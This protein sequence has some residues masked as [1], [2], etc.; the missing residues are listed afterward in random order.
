MPYIDIHN[1]RVWI[2]ER[3][4][5][6][7]DEAR[8]MRDGDLWRCPACGR[9]L[10]EEENDDGTITLVCPAHQVGWGAGHEDEPYPMGGLVFRP[11][12]GGGVF[13]A[14]PCMAVCLDRTSAVNAFF[15]LGETYGLTRIE[16]V[17]PRTHSRAGAATR[18]APPAGRGCSGRPRWTAARPR[19]SACAAGSNARWSRWPARPNR[20]RGPC[21]RSTCWPT[22]WTRMSCPRAHGTGDGLLPLVH[23]ARQI[24]LRFDEQIERGS[25]APTPKPA[26]QA[27][28]PVLGR[29][30]GVRIDA[31]QVGVEQQRVG[32]IQHGLQPHELPGGHGLDPARPALVLADMA[33]RGADGA[34][35]LGLRHARPE[36]V[37]GIHPT[38]RIHAHSNAHTCERMR[39]MDTDGL[40][41]EQLLVDR[42]T[43]MRMLGVRDPRTVNKL[44]RNGRITGFTACGRWYF[45][46]A[47][48]E[49]FARGE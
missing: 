24:E 5:R 39:D 6:S 30:D 7:M 33:L 43:A 26:A 17:R 37:H 28:D 15:A 32:D 31:G 14:G 40:P 36:P 29:R 47:S 20:T 48:I 13:I 27:G 11:T 38:R 35:Q 49:A 10:D 46:R 45:N 9:E 18:T 8:P 21:G 19:W 4:L 3:P 41:K 16:G 34:G 23:A 2:P 22:R 12:M 44:V 25:V 42:P 1:E